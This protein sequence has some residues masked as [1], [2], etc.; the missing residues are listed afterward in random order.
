M[1]WWTGGSGEFQTEMN[2]RFDAIE[3]RLEHLE[4][5]YQ[6]IVSALKRIEERLETDSADRSRLTAEVG[7]LKSKIADLDTRVRELEER[8]AGE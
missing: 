4:I 2:G 1:R 8:L 5:E 6:M 3:R 7:Q